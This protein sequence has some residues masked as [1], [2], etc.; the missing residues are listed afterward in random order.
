MTTSL[1]IALTLVIFLTARAISLN[2]KCNPTK[3]GHCTIA[4]LPA[5]YPFGRIGVQVNQAETITDVTVEDV[6]FDEMPAKFFNTFKSLDTLS[7]EKGELTSLAGFQRSSTLENLYVIRNKLMAINSGDL[8]SS[9]VYLELPYNRIE[10]IDDEAFT[11]LSNLYWL[12]LGYNRIEEVSRKMIAPSLTTLN[13]E[14]NILRRVGTDFANHPQLKFLNLSKNR[15]GKIVTERTFAGLTALKELDLSNNWIE[16]VECGAFRDS[17]SLVVLK[18]SNNRM[19]RLSFEVASTALKKLYVDGN[20]LILMCVHS[21]RAAGLLSDLKLFA[22]NNALS[23]IRFSDA[24]PITSL[25]LDNNEISSIAFLKKL[26]K[27]EQLSLSGNDLSKARFSVL[28][29][30]PIKWLNLENTNLSP[31]KFKEVLSLDNLTELLNVSKNKQLGGFYFSKYSSPVAVLYMNECGFG[32]IDIEE[33]K[34]AFENLKELQV[35]GN[36]FDCSTLMR[37]QEEIRET[38]IAVKCGA[39]IFK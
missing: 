25:T 31:G 39:K 20:R 35:S 16:T 30:F 18:L 13:L 38:Q 9:V 29:N 2:L 3:H 24:L 26:R 19:V 27:L 1:T 17:K 10:V 33:M 36:S 15:L 21:N 4:H 37:Q 11:S 14:S 12:D 28:H 5:D 22:Q 8:A 34:G 32:A 6:R 23:D 7:I